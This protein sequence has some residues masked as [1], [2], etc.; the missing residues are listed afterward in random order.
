MKNFNTFGV[1]R[2]IQFLGGSV[3]KKQIYRRGLP[4][5][6]DWKFVDVRGGLARKRGSVFEGGLIPHTLCPSTE[7][8]VNGAQETESLNSYC[9][10]LQVGQ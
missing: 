9:C 6:R 1:H 4:E 7:I 3:L 10:L 2:K 5:R 8:Y